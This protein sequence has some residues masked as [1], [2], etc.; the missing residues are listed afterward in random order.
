MINKSFK[1]NSLEIDKYLRTE[2]NFD[3][4]KRVIEINNKKSALYFIDGLLKDEI[5]EKLMEFF[6]SIDDS[7]FSSDPELFME[8]C[9]PYVEV[10]GEND[11]DKIAD[12][13]FS[14]ALA[15]TV[16]TIDKVFLID[17]RTYPQRDTAEPEDDKTLRGSRDGFVETLINNCSLIRRRIR[18]RNLTVKAYRAGTKSKTDIALIYMD[19]LVDKKLLKTITEKIEN[20]N[21]ASLTMNEQSLIESLYKKKWYNPFPKVKYTE[22]PDTTAS[23]ILKGNIIIIVDNSPSAMIIPTSIFDIMEEA[24]DYYFPPITG[25][26]LRLTRYFISILSII[27]TPLWLL[28][29][30]N[31]SYVPDAFRFILLTEPQNIPIF[32]QLIIIEI[33]I[34]GMRL[35]SLNT[36]NSLTTTLGIIGAIALSDFSVEAGWFSMEAILYMAFVTIANYSQPN[37]EL[38]FS[39]KFIRIML[40]ILTA[41]FNLWGLIGGIILTA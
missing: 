31:P 9:I 38:G 36:P 3:I 15:L 6:Y 21:K 23:A 39:M 18:D 12:E 37:Y 22:R 33:G 5:A 35:A 20:I 14:G 41:L 32:W 10:K 7:A 8:R 24:N 13:I 2:E 27:I 34:D 25:T 11:I 28:F 1:N 17:S 19:N 29:L 30:Q 26:Y 16:D 4:V 40:L